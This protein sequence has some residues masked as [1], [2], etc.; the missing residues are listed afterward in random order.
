MKTQNEI[1]EIRLLRR[2]EIQKQFDKA[3]TPNS[4]VREVGEKYLM[5]F[6]TEVEVEIEVEYKPHAFLERSAG[7]VKAATNY[8]SQPL[9]K[10][11]GKPIEV[12]PPKE[13]LPLIL[14]ACLKAEQRMAKHNKKREVRHDASEKGFALLLELLIVCIVS[15]V[16]FAM[17]V[18][19]FMKLRASEDM[20]SAET[21]VRLI[22][23]TQANLALCSV[24]PSC[25]P[26]MAVQ[27]IANAPS[28]VPGGV[29]QIGTYTYTW[30]SINGNWNYTAMS[31]Q[32]MSNFYVD[33]SNVVRCNRLAAIDASAPV[34]NY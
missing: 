32:G 33:G 6:S 4:T 2:T 16:L 29:M 11:D 15:S 18:V 13:S 9:L 21:Q 34:C 12:E 23:N 24:T 3:R 28:L 1:A 8:Y 25:I 19:P 5:E 17:A 30:N 26:S 27:N 31:N 7:L 22:G 14:A 10:H 20:H